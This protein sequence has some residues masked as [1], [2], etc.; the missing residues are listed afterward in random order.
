MAIDTYTSREEKEIRSIRSHDV[1][2]HASHAHPET[3]EE[4]L[5]LEL[6]CFGE[7]ARAALRKA[8]AGAVEVIA[9][10]VL[11]REIAASVE[12][13][14]LI[15]QA[16]RRFEREFPIRARVAPQDLGRVATGLPVVADG[17]LAA[18]DFILELRES[19]QES[20]LPV[21]FACTYRR[22]EHNTPVS[23]HEDMPAA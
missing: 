9:N 13:E 20:R 12:V 10:D 17:S 11:S 6:E 22:L 3:A 16:L 1:P 18:G 4:K 19:G 8:V 2:H 23:I 7:L 14:A 15:A 21:H 5:L